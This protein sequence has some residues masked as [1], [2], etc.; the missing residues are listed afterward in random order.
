MKRTFL[1]KKFKEYYKKANA[2]RDGH[3]DTMY[4]EGAEELKA[5]LGLGDDYED[6]IVSHQ[7]EIFYTHVKKMEIEKQ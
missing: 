2:E 6:Q 3:V 7:V 1:N 4:H 5:R